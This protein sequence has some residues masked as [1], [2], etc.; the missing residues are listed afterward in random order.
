MNASK[1]LTDGALLTGIYIV[2]LLIST[3]VPV[4]SIFSIFLLPI[5]FIIYASKYD[6]KPSFLMLT[7][8]TILSLIFATIFSLPMTILAGLGGIMIGIAIHHNIS[9]YETWARGTVGFIAGLLFVFLFSQVIFQVNWMEEL[10]Q[11]IQESME[12]SRSTLEQF[13]LGEQTEE[14]FEIIEEQMMFIKDLVPFA[15]AVIAIILALVSQ[16]FSYKILNRIEN[17]QLA[18]PPFRQLRM[19]ISLIWIYFF[20]LILSF[21][22]LEPSSTL[23]LGVTNVLML[24]GMFMTIQGFSFIFFYAHHKKISKALPIGIVVA[25]VLLPFVLLYLVRL[26]GIIDIGFGLRDRIAKQSN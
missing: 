21:F 11:T 10:D 1:K 4:I 12:M 9:P 8:A 15:I 18:F 3:F 16:W 14:Q 7:V 24:A 13:G 23:Y 22:S 5:P 19:P 26:V 17:R 6:W 20:A 25:T 2:L